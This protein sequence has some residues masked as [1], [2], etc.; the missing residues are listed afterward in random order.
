MFLLMYLFFMNTV[1][2]QIRLQNNPLKFTENKGQ[3]IPAALYSSQIPNGDLCLTQKG[4]AYIFFDQK[5][6]EELMHAKHASHT[7]E[8]TPDSIVIPQHF[9]RANFIKSNEDFQHFGSKPTSD[10]TNYLIGKRD[11]WKTDISSFKEVY[12]TEIYNG[13]DFK[14]YEHGASLKYEYIVAPKANPKKIKIEFEGLDSCFLKNEALHLVTSVNEITEQK[15]YAYQIIND[16]K[17]KVDCRFNLKGNKL[18]YSL[19]KYNKDLPLIIDPQLI[20]STSSGSTA[21]NWGNTACLDQEGNLYAGGTIF[22]TTASAG[23]F[24]NTNFVYGFLDIDGFPVTPGAFQTTFSF[25]PNTPT[26]TDGTNFY[27]RQSDHAKTDIGV[28]KFD[29]SGTTLLYSTYIGGLDTDIPVSINTNSNNELVILGVTGSNNFPEAINA[30]NAGA[31]IPPFLGVYQFQNSADIIITTLSALGNDLIASRYMGG[32]GADGVMAD[33]DVLVNNYGDQLRG[34]II[35][36]N[37]NNIICAS[38]SKSIDFP[39]ANAADSTLD[40]DLDAVLFSLSPDLATVNWSTYYG[41]D[42]DDAAYSI[43]QDSEGSIV[44]S[45][46]SNSPNLDSISSFGYNGDVDGFIAKLSANG[47]TLIGSAY[48]GTPNFD[49]SYFVDIDQDD[50]IYLF[51]QT[52]GQYTR[53]DSVYFNENGGQFLHKISKDLSTTMYAT[54]FGS[55]NPAGNIVPNISPTAFLVNDCENVFVSGWGGETNTD[56]NGGWTFGMPLKDQTKGDDETDSSDFY[57]AVFLKDAKDVLFGTYFGG[58]E[59]QEHVDGGTSRFDKQGIVYQS[60]CSGCGSNTDFPTFPDDGSQNTYPMRNASGNCNLGVFKYD[61]SSLEAELEVQDRDCGN[62]TVRLANNSVGGVDFTWYFGDGD[63]LFTYSKDT[64]EHLYLARGEYEIILV[65]TDLTT[66]TG[67]DTARATVIIGDSIFASGPDT[68][69]FQE[70]AQLK[71]ENSINP[72]WV[73]H[74]DLSCSTCFN[75]IATPVVTS[76]TYK[77]YEVIAPDCIVEDSVTVY[78]YPDF[79][80]DIEIADRPCQQDLVIFQNTSQAASGFIWNFGDG[81]PSLETESLIVTHQY[82]K[83]GIYTVSLFGTHAEPL[84]ANLTDIALTEVKFLDSLYASGHDT[85]CFGE[86]TFIRV[87][88]ATNPIWE[89]LHV[90]KCVEGTNCE[91][92][93]VTPPD[94]MYYYVSESLGEDCIVRDSVL[95]DMYPLPVPV[96]TILYKNSRCWDRPF[97]LYAGINNNDCIC[98]DPVQGWKWDFGDGNFSEE[99]NPSHQYDAPG[100]Y[101]ITLYAYAHDTVKHTLEV[102]VFHQDSCLKN[103]YIPNAFTPNDDGENDKLYVRAINVIDVDFHVFNRWGEEVFTSYS[104][105]HGWDGIYKGVKQ[106]H[107]VYT[108]TCNAT[109]WD[110]EK[111]FL[112]G[113]VTLIE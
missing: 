97:E 98:C 7:G 43:K 23:G 109:F 73:A 49:Q 66:C 45:G 78:M 3:F 47:S 15:P 21:D 27:I 13:I 89:D 103:I 6:H 8:E 40:G 38:F 50:D 83:T 51:G 90:L 22:G 60:V 91:I 70:Q 9:F 65:A 76:T 92:A 41:G 81:S 85:I 68:I 2:A 102:T 34:D 110:G 16:T 99:L 28:M 17:V 46:G 58:N 57:L 69:C 87:D 53:S 35:T 71:V 19:G 11:N 105:Q 56:Y 106:T 12:Y 107:Q 42:G 18:S 100:T 63:T 44:F 26:W 67:K 30:F 74:P 37:N 86:S 52:K 93:L 79:S 32:T 82:K 104:L 88:S 4:L 55:V 48:L 29:S 5:A 75:P 31:A 14:I 33:D 39:V 59:S 20:F 108:Y 111:V 84:C 95:I 113:N 25:D 64:V 94:S 54:T 62:K 112:E 10:K 72:V 77:V 96:P 61:L 80:I 24:I 101:D 1:H 36:D